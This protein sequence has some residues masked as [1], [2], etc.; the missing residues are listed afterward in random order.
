MDIKPITQ[1]L[2]ELG[3]VALRDGQG[4]A[5]ELISQERWN[6]Q[7]DQMESTFLLFDL[8]QIRSIAVPFSDVSLDI[9]DFTT[10]PLIYHTLANPN[11]IDAPIM[12]GQVRFAMIKEGDWNKLLFNFGKPVI[13]QPITDERRV[14]I[15]IADKFPLVGRGVKQMFV[16]PEGEVK[17]LNG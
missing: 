2:K 3:R 5:F 16:G 17:I 12:N 4:H 9:V 7:S 1:L 14:D 13:Y 10:K 11:L 8:F 15:D 6:A